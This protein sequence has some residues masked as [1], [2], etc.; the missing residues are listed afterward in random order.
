MADT[1]TAPSATTFLGTLLGN[2][3]PSA[4]V[5]ASS[6]RHRASPSTPR[7][8]SCSTP[9][10]VRHPATSQRRVPGGKEHGGVRG[11]CDRRPAE[12]CRSGLPPLGFGSLVLY[13]AISAL[14]GMSY[15]VLFRNEASS[16]GLGIAWGWLF[17][18]LWWYL[19]RR[20]KK[21]TGS[22]VCHCRACGTEDEGGLILPNRHAR[23]LASGPALLSVSGP[24]WAD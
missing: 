12:A 14:I 2:E 8:D 19:G 10:R 4:Q 16:P 22:R 11:N 5:A 15:G 21:V 18:L 17:S 7:R 9:L 23:G 13:L 3:A 20:G 24:S 6:T 1:G